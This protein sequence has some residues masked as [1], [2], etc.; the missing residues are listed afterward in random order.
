M[1][2]NEEA[3]KR[4]TH[5]QM[6]EPP[7]L[8]ASDAMVRTHDG[9]RRV[10][11]VGHRNPDSDS[12]CSAIAYAY[13]K[14]EMTR[15]ISE[16]FGVAPTEVFIPARAGKLNLETKF[17]LDR[18]GFASP[19]Y[20]SDVYPRVQDV[21]V[22]ARTL[23][24]HVLHPD[25]TLREL[26]DT[27]FR[28]RQR[29]PATPVLGATHHIN[30][31][32]SSLPPLPVAA[33]TAGMAEGAGAPE[34]AAAR[35]PLRSSSF[36][37]T[38]GADEKPHAH[39]PQPPQLD[40]HGD[41]L[42][43]IPVVNETTGRLEGA[44]SM[45]DL[46]ERYMN[47]LDMQ[48]LSQAGVSFAHVLKTL[49][50]TLLTPIPE[51]LLRLAR[52]S[53]HDSKGSTPMTPGGSSSSNGG[54]GEEGAEDDPDELE[55]QIPRR[56]FAETETEGEPTVEDE[57]NGEEEE[58][59]END[60]ENMA[61]LRSVTVKGK[62]VI[63]AD[64]TETMDV[65]D[66]DVAIV[67][68]R[69]LAQLFCIQKNASCLILTNHS[70]GQ[71]APGKRHR[72]V[73]GVDEQV[74]EAARARGVLL[75]AT[76]YDTYSCARLINQSV[77]LRL[78]MNKNVR[79][80]QRTDL[81]SEVKRAVT[82]ESD[83]QFRFFPVVNKRRHFL[84]VIPRDALL[85]ASRY[86]TDLILVDHNERS[87]GVEG[88]EE[89]HL[90]E[91]IDHHRLGGLE[92]GEPIFIRH[93]PVGAT[94]TIV[95]NMSWHRGI[96]IPPNIAGLLL[97]AIVSDTLL[98]K[99]PTC[100]Q[101]DRDTAAR[102]AAAAGI[103]NLTDFGVTVLRSGS[104]IA[105]RAPIDIVTTDMKE[106]DLGENRVAVAQVFVMSHE[107]IRERQDAIQA[108]MVQ[109]LPGAHLD[110]ICLCVTDILKETSMLIHAGRLQDLIT[111]AFGEPVQTKP[112]YIWLL[113]GVMSRKSQ[114]IPPL[115]QS[116]RYFH[117]GQI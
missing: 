87:Q 8:S 88:I 26:G 113:P 9:L 80:F 45:Q 111:H 53:L 70:E 3:I 66:N 28:M 38:P 7:G 90:V 54:A 95:A 12:I 2:G 14:N 65:E 11:I 89:A 36:I 51:K 79:A 25:Q 24:A 22:P 42:V 115:M 31:P 15:L 18:F 46:A 52:E 117:R 58:E 76:Q 34:G 55:L 78:V 29:T 68:N 44:I 116:V 5:Y 99:S 64:D 112:Y 84:G 13:L 59:E 67:G 30:P 81:L 56:P 100:T 10:F 33:A 77:P 16:K 6:E 71:R 41:V 107:D 32:L 73:T 27:L 105:Q 82:S 94:A 69:V 4:S 93:E 37:Y 19:H 72:L 98:F 47:E 83:S 60:G 75:V 103:A 85:D 74:M 110:M 91:I 109:V 97:A 101:K 96:E 108:A 17:I 61:L 1:S 106:F 114:I 43:P 62:V 35:T 63:A 23:A 40:L 49:H 50:G 21:L 102:L 48:D 86:A 39:A 92:T 20:L 57:R 104:V